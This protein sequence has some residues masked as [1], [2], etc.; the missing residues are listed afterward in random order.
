MALTEK[1]PKRKF[2]GEFDSKEDWAAEFV[3]DTGGMESLID[4]ER[5]YR[6]DK[7]GYP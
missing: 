4:P 5:F 2:L 1:R 3:A 6:I 7:V